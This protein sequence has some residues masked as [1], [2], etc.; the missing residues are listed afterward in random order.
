MLVPVS[1]PF[2][3]LPPSVSL[4]LFLSLCFLFSEVWEV[5]QCSL[6]IAVADLPAFRKSQDTQVCVP[7]TTAVN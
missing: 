5:L 7:H 1:S 3:H 2:L 6:L 4:P